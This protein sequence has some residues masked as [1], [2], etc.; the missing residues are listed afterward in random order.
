M[1]GRSRSVFTTTGND[2]IGF[3]T[4]FAKLCKL[5]CGGTDVSLVCGFSWLTQSHEFDASID[6]FQYSCF[7]Q[8]ACSTALRGNCLFTVDIGES[9]IRGQIDS[10]RSPP[11]TH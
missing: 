2:I 7:G 4:S 1:G 6:A 3:K 8:R 10:E 5:C 9:D 11:L